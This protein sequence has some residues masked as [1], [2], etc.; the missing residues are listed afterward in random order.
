MTSYGETTIH[1]TLAELDAGLLLADHSE[2]ERKVSLMDADISGE[3]AVKL[4]KK[5][6]NNAN[7]N[8]N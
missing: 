4:L 3:N 8:S 7:K 6:E 5:F 2:K 1:A